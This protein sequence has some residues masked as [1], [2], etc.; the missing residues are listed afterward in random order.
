MIYI[1][2]FKVKTIYFYTIIIQRS[3]TSSGFIKKNYPIVVYRNSISFIK[4]T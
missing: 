3:Y 1:I 2:F 4:S